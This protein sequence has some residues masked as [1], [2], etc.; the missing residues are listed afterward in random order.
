[1]RLD[2][3]SYKHKTYGK[4]LKPRFTIVEWKMADGSEPPAVDREEADLD[5]LDDA[6]PDFTL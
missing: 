1:M 6:V 5:E 2:S 3:E 4:V